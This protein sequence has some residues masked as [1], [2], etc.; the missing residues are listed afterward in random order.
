MLL[1]FKSFHRQLSSRNLLDKKHLLDY[2][3][4]KKMHNMRESTNLLSSLDEKSVPT[5]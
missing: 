2:N 4:C 5:T 1:Y 3:S